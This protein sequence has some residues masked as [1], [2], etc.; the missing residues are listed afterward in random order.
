MEFP[1]KRQVTFLMALKYN[2][3]LIETDSHTGCSYTVKGEINCANIVIATVGKVHLNMF[4]PEAIL[5]LSD[6]T[7]GLPISN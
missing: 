2:Q 4:F 6:N 5:N 1:G 3:G 7:S